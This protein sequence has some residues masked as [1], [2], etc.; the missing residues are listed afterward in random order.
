MGLIFDVNVMNNTMKEI[1]YDAKRMPLG[2]LG[3][4][5]IK[6]AYGILNKL[7]EAIK[8]KQTNV[9]RQ[10]SSDFYTLIPHDF[11]FQKMANFVLDNEEKVKEKLKMLET[12]S[13]MKITT[14]LLEQK[15]ND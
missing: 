10:L 12:I 13:D 3:D 4:G 15:S 1:G 9:Y 7:S 5:T 14:K 8:N 6:E 2:K 11:G